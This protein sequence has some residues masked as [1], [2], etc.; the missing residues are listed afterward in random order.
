M[1]VVLPWLLYCCCSSGLEQ[2]AEFH[3]PRHWRAVQIHDRYFCL[4]KHER[5]SNKRKNKQWAELFWWIKKNK[6]LWSETASKMSGFLAYKLFWI[7][8]ILPIAIEIHYGRC[9]LTGL[10]LPNREA[11]CA[12]GDGFDYPTCL[13]LAENLRHKWRW[14]RYPLSCLWKLLRSGELTRCAPRWGTN[15]EGREGDCAATELLLWGTRRAGSRQ[16]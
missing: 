4:Q 1:Q 12:D 6:V 8:N 2:L 14:C 16:H 9:C 10:D 7:T 3:Y 11:R 13:E 15:R 5:H